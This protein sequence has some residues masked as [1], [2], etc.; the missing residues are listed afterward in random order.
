MGPLPPCGGGLG[1]GC[2]SAAKCGKDEFHD[3]VGVLKDIVVP[4]PNDAVAL[5]LEPTG[6]PCVALKLSSVLTA[7]D[8]DDE[9]A[10]KADEIDDEPSDG[11]LATEKASA[12]FAVA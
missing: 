3:P 10:L 6:A 12:E 5:A 4:E 9:L 7:I 8:F 11:R 2:F 1:G